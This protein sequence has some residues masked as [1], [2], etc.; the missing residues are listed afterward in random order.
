MNI[1]VKGTV[2]GYLTP[3]VGIIEVRDS[4]GESK[5]VK[6]NLFHGV[7]LGSG[8]KDKYS[9]VIPHR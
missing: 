6:E 4:K 1:K 7:I 9:G 3:E 5:K 8:C 2:I